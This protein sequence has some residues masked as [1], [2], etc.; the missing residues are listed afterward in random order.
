MYPEQK[1]ENST[2]DL[3][4][5]RSPE[6]H[7]RN[8]A[9]VNGRPTTLPLDQREYPSGAPDRVIRRVIETGCI[10]NMSQHSK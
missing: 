8:A 1:P 9:E 7:A 2:S 10:G 3:P 6:W 4:P 5:Y